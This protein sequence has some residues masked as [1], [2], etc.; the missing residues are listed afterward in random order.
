VLILDN[1]YFI[2]AVF[3]RVLPRLWQGSS[4]NSADFSHFDNSMTA[5]VTIGISWL[6]LHST[7]RVHRLLRV[8]RP[9]FFTLATITGPVPWSAA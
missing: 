6:C 9:H 8:A 4:L 7:A 2:F 3:D 1:V 5:A